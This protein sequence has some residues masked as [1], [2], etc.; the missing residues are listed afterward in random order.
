MKAFELRH[1]AIA[2][3]AFA[4]SVG[5]AAAAATADSQPSAAKNTQP[6]HLRVG[7]ALTYAVTLELQQH[8]SR[9]AP[10][11]EERSSESS[12]EGTETVSIY[13][14]ASDGTALATVNAMFHGTQDG[15][16]VI[17]QTSFLAKVLPNGEMRAHG[18]LGRQ[19]EEAFNFANTSAH[20]IAAHPQ[21]AGTAWETVQQTPYASITIA[22][23]VNGRKT[24]Q[25]FPV[26]EVQS[27][28]TGLLKRTS[29]GQRVDGTIQLSGTSYYDYRDGLMI[30]ESIR[31]L[32]IANASGAPPAHS[33]YSAA[34]N[35]MLSSL[36][37]AKPAAPRPGQAVLQKAPNGA[38]APATNRQNAAASPPSSATLRPTTS[39]TPGQATPA[40][41]PSGYA[42]SPLPTVTP[43]TEY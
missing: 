32:T 38:Q 1:F 40:P 4:M 2:V 31:T 23:K 12:G 33:N 34:L 27:V 9:M 7:D 10:K 24:Y 20:E 29:D 15:Q 14:I 19:I 39:P 36:A 21:A 8:H 28:G 41:A 26:I 35:V 17:L 16:P 6:G 43:R 25:G 22:R 11:L 3:I 13:H 18:G 30:G 5:I 42:A 37:R